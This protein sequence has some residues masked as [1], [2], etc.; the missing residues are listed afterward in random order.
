MYL[1]LFSGILLLV[2]L[3]GYLVL[4]KAYS[5]KGSLKV[6][7]QIISWMVIAIAFAGTICTT[8]NLHCRPGKYKAGYGHKCGLYSK[9]CPLMQKEGGEHPAEHPK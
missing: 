3:A 4:V 6:I 2:M 9:Q 1:G 5:Q 8:V 7:G